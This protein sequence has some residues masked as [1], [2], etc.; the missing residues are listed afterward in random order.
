MCPIC[1]HPFQKALKEK[2]FELVIV[3]NQKLENLC[4][5][6][7]EERKS[8][9]EKVQ[10]AGGHPNVNAAAPTEKEDAEVQDTTKDPKDDHQVENTA[11]PAETPTL[12]TPLTKELAQL[13]AE[14]T[15]LKE[16]AGSFT[17]SHVIPTDTE[18]TS[19][20]QGLSEGVQE[21]AE[22]HIEAS[23]SEHLQ[24]AKEDGNQEQRDLEMESVD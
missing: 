4:R 8:L 10:G 7:Q 2:E 14:Q 19:Q 12:N 13:K 18:V 1:L 3:K 5:A 17:I 22:N 23:N 16:I 20:S 15:R 6:L 24:E 11:A 21:P 9:Y